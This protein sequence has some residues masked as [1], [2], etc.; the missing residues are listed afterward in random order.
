MSTLTAFNLKKWIDEHR[1]R[2]KP[3]VGNAEVFPNHDFIVMI[4]GG[5]NARKD[6]HVNPTEELFYQIEGDVTLKVIENGNKRD[7]PIREG[8][9]FLLPPM[10]PHSPQ[11]P[12]NTVGMVVE[13]RRPEG[14]EDHLQFYC[15]KCGAIVHEPKFD[16]KDI[17]NQLKKIMT[18]FWDPGNTKLRTCKKCG[19]VMAPPVPAK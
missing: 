1:D 14:K 18:E 16:M 3:P 10:I 9:I 5:P 7:I 12:P 6:Y 19:T 4:V 8:D 13:R 11:R 15:D 2:L 17:V